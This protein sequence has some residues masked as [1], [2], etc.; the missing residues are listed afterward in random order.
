MHMQSASKHD[1]RT[2][3]SFVMN[4]SVVINWSCHLNEQITFISTDTKDVI[5][6]DTAGYISIILLHNTQL[7]VKS[8]DIKSLDSPGNIT[9]EI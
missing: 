6:A 5:F 2:N 4:S 1:Y 7:L 3:L 9:R 8:I